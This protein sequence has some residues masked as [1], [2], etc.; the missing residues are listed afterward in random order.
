MKT[1]LFSSLLT[2][3]VLL[4][5]CSSTKKIEALKPEPSNNTP[6][7]YQ[8]TNSF[9][10]LPVS[11]TIS[12]IE[13]QVNK[14]LTGMVYEDKNIEDDNIAMQVWKTAPI[15]FSEQTGKLQ[16]IVPIKVTANVRYGTSALGMNLYDTREVNLDGIVT[17]KSKVGL[18]NWKMKTDT[19]IESIDWNESPTVTI[20]G[21][22]V[23]ITYAINPS[24]KLFKSKIENKLDEAMAKTMDFKPQVLDAL[25]KI[26]TP[27]LTSEQYETWFKLNP[28]ELYATDAILSKKQ[29]TLEM[30][31]KCS[32]LTMVGQ[33]PKNTFK[34]ED[35][36][37]KA[38]TKMPD[39]I[40]AVVAAVSTY[41]SASKII[42][43]N[44]QGQEF[45]SGKRKVTVQK[46]DLWNKDGKMVV[47]LDMTGS[48][49]GTIY[50]TGYPNYNAITKEIY[51]DQMD[52]VLSTKS[53]LMKTAN[54]LAE[55]M[56]LRKIQENCRY[57][58]KDNLDQ[59]KKSLLP[60]L[61]N[62]SPM[63][64]IFV[65]G[66]LNDFE[67]DKVELTDK[68]IIAFIKGSGKMDLKIDGMK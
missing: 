18:S 8:S 64:G 68:A 23:P 55:G 1:L 2:A 52:Y 29:V 38:V 9:I 53:V 61:N 14:M 33:K 32:M 17:L 51:F 34:K 62:Y 21:K 47:A 3:S 40:S 65:N 22:K 26:S 46:V 60:Y 25:E 31:L 42:T 49:N 48:I 6:L 66:T 36:V 27:F 20:A 10:N 37:L 44:F 56:I 50:L 7:V 11:I 54:W 12:D 19:T 39:N 28:I 67:F 24:I 4:S 16:V 43:K 63:A 45:G 57:S 58:I 30:G 59:G 13:T 15:K 5:G 35:I 41:E